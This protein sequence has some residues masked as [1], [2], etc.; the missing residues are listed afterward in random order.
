MGIKIE[1]KGFAKAIQDY[2]LT[3]NKGVVEVLNAKAFDVVATAMGYTPRTTADQLTKEMRAIEIVS[4]IKADP[5]YR[6]SQ[7]A[8][9]LYNRRKDKFGNIKITPTKNFYKNKPE[10]RYAQSKSQE[11]PVGF[12]IANYRRKLKG[13]RGLG[14]RQM[15]IYFDRFIKALRSS[16]GYIRAGWIPALELFRPWSKSKE[17]RMAGLKASKPLAEAFKKGASSKL[18]NQDG[19]ALAKFSTYP[20]FKASFY[21]SAKGADIIEQRD[22]PLKKAMFDVEMDMRGY[23]TSYY[24]NMARARGL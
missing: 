13:K 22:S 10:L 3:T 17:A 4:N 12:L 8:G 20:I 9:K 1:T 7:Q 18:L 16:A 15:G 23:L 19:G 5:F 6:K 24:H 11:V 21:N 2:M 14:G